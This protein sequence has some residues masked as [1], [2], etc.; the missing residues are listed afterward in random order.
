ME[1]MFSGELL[2]GETIS[3][4]GQPETS[5]LFTGSDIF[6]VPFSVLWGGFAIFWEFGATAA[7][8]PFFFSL[9]GVPFV[10]VGL[11]FIFG[12]FIYKH[13]RKKNTFYAV[14]NK[15]VLCLTKLFRHSIR[16]AFINSI[17]SI[18]KTVKSNGV[19]SIKFGEGSWI[20]SMYGN[21]GMEFFGSFY[22]QDALAFY[23][24]K[25]V[26][27]VYSLINDLRNKQ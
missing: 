27:N 23:D 2:N 5:V 12:R 14:T 24:I 9:F 21:S 26:N 20:A 8:A 7:G 11:Y 3:W 18:N 10:L 1:E 25:D 6:L 13:Y 15:R 4:V 19:G 16:E 17:S 22:G